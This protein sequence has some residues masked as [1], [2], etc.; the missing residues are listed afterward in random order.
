MQWMHQVFPAYFKSSLHPVGGGGASK[1]N[2][3][4][5]KVYIKP[6]QGQRTHRYSAEAKYV[7]HELSG[8]HAA[9][10]TAAYL[11]NRANSKQSPHQF[12]P[13]LLSIIQIV[14]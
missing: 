8:F 4:H 9:H 13:P 2:S 3:M 11:R 1:P 10:L 12:S 7:E 5:F 6:G 14:L